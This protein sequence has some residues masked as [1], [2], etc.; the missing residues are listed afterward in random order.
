MEYSGTFIV[1]YPLDDVNNYFSDINNVIPC[2]PG[3]YD[4]KRGEIIQCRV[5]FDISDE[6]IGN[7]STVSG[8]MSFKYNKNENRV[9][10][11]GKGKIEGSKIVFNIDITYEKYNDKTS[12]TWKSKFD[13]GIL[14]RLIGI[15]KV[16][17]ISL[18]NI[19]QTIHC[20]ESRLVYN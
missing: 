5:K 11:N 13:F 17:D 4:L 2:L 8:K 12:I 3:I 16:E 10:I 18:K 19:Q 7:L 15:Q 9:N 20:I 1:D 6:G 14:M